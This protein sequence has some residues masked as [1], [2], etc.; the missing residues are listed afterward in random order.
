ME[1]NDLL[2]KMVSGYEVREAIFDMSPASLAGP[3]GFNSTFYHKC[4]SIIAT[5]VIEFVKSFFNGNNLTRFYSHTCL[6]LI[7]KVESPSTLAEFRPIGLSNFSAKII[8]KILAR[9]LNPLLPKLISE[10]QSGFVKGRLITY[11]V[12]LTQEIIH[13]ISDPNTGGN[14]VIKLDMAKAYDRVSWEFL[15]SVI[16][17]FDFSSWWT[18]IIGRLIS[19]V[20]YSIIVNGTRRGFFTSSQGLK[21][22]DRLSPSLFILGAEVFSRL[23]NRLYD[24]QRF[25]PFSMNNRGPKINHL[26]YADD[27]VIFCGGKSKSIKL[28]M[29]QIRL[30][31]KS[32]GQKVNEDKS[33]F[34]TSPKVSISRDNMMIDKTGYKHKHGGKAIL[35]KHV[36]QAHTLAAMIPPKGTLKLM[37]RHLARFFWGTS[38]D[39]QRYHWSAWENLCYSKEEGGIGIKRMEAI[40]DSFAYQR[41]WKFR[42]EDSLWASLLRAKYCSRVHPVAKASSSKQSHSWGKLM[43]IKRKAEQNLTWKIQMGNNNLRWDNWTGKGALAELIPC[44]AK[45]AKDKVEDYI[46]GGTWNVMKLA[47]IIPVHIISQITKLMIG[48]KNTQDYAIWDPA[49][50]GQFSTKSTHHLTRTPRQKDQFRYKFWHPNLPFKI[51]FLAWRLIQRKLPFD[52]TMRIFGGNVVSECVCCNDTKRETFQ[53]VFLEGDAGNR[54]WK[55]FGGP[56]GIDVNAISINNMLRKWW[57]IKPKNGIWGTEENVA[58]NHGTPDLVDN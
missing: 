34:C 44:Q 31:E 53:H 10:N 5:D 35:I 16:R 51:S 9:R 40:S 12:L 24:D 52:D 37:Q 20:W 6:V 36:L 28:V 13:G 15:L 19:E 18:E 48:D 43:Q 11:N 21:Q 58:E 22:G 30:Y 32:S 55:K 45:F 33:F 14:M 29:K 26:A 46:Q 41:W 54:M 7:P 3:D 27:M 38:N 56:L 4:W 23:L 47:K 39:K 25:I 2:S 1:D 49:A 57:K 50:D 17:N 8:S 42:T